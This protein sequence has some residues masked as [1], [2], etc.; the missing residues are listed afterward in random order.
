MHWRRNPATHHAAT[1]SDEGIPKPA[2]AEG[3]WSAADTGAPYRFCRGGIAVE[4][5]GVEPLS[6]S[7]LL[8]LLRA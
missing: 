7:D 1:M 3:R 8:G 5:R 6:L 2:E 4:V